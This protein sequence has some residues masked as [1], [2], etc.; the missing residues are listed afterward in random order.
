MGLCQED[1]RSCTA[2]LGSCPLQDS[3]SMAQRQEPKP[4]EQKCLDSELALG[5]RAC[6]SLGLAS[7]EVTAQSERSRVLGATHQGHSC[8]WPGSSSWRVGR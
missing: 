1:S 4:P 8:L 6:C 7:K 2:L 5:R 3:D